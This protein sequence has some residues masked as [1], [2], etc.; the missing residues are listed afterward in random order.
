MI[1]VFE[2]GASAA[3]QPAGNER[4]AGD[5]WVR[6]LRALRH[7]DG[8][9]LRLR[10]GQAGG[11]RALRNNECQNQE[12]RKMVWCKSRPRP[13]IGVEGRHAETPET[14]FGGWCINFFF[15]GLS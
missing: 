11:D 14:G 3:E 5:G 12:W 6:L 15:F 8:Q 9:A 13:P 2:I 1:I 4:G 7:Q 10:P